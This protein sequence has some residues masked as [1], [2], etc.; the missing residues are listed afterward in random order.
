MSRSNGRHLRPRAWLDHALGG[1]GRFGP[2]IARTGR[3]VASGD[4]QMTVWAH[5]PDHWIS[6]AVCRLTHTRLPLRGAFVAGSILTVPCRCRPRGD[7]VR[8]GGPEVVRCGQPG[9]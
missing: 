4:P 7:S 2:R 3:Y 8:S 6:S 5:R 1:R 9:G